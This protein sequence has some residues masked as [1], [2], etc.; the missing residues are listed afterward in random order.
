[1]TRAEARLIVEEVAK[2]MKEQPN[3]QEQM[4]SVKELADFLR[5]S[6][7]YIQLHINE[8]PSIR[9]GKRILFPK[10]KILVTH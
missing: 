1:M 8:F 7:R 4:M 5:V 2:I 9:I 6:R 10:S 3:M